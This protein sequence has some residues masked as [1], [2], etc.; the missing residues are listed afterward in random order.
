MRRN[1]RATTSNVTLTGAEQQSRP[2]VRA[3][4]PL[5]SEA[6]LARMRRRPS[7]RCFAIVPPASCGVL[8]RA[9]SYMAFRR[10][11][12]MSWWRSGTFCGLRPPARD[13]FRC[14]LI[15]AGWRIGTWSHTESR[16]VLDGRTERAFRPQPAAV[17]RSS[18]LAAELPLP[19]GMKRLCGTRPWLHCVSPATGRP[20][21][22]ARL[23]GGHGP[24]R[25]R[26]G[27]GRPPG[28]PLTT[29]VRTARAAPD[30]R[31]G[32]RPGAAASPAPLVA[33]GASAAPPPPRRQRPEPRRPPP[34]PW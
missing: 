26:N 5:A 19:V 20:V 33:G 24:R 17:R 29:R 1:S 7:T 21:H 22:P 9:T 11:L 14:V 12:S 30:P 8:L 4:F 6:A 23:L 28:P 25:R 13:A 3:A 27:V 16:L 34:S 2:V 10:S 18:G 32:V 15:S 31:R